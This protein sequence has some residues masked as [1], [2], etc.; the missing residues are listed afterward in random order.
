LAG[1]AAGSAEI[2]AALGR[3]EAALAGLASALLAPTQAFKTFFLSAVTGAQQQVA[4][5]QRISASVATIP[6]A[7]AGALSGSERFREGLRT[8]TAQIRDAAAAMEALRVPAAAIPAAMAGALSGSERFR[9]GLR[10]VTTQ[11]QAAAAAIAA[12]RVPVAAIPAAMA[13]AASGTA[14]FAAGLRTLELQRS[15]AAAAG[16]AGTPWAR[17]L[18]AREAQQAAGATDVWARGLRNLTEQ[19]GIA[20]GASR[21]LTGSLTQHGFAARETARADL[22]LR[23]SL[24]VLAAQST[25][26]SSTLA[27]LAEGL[28]LIGRSTKVVIGGFAAILAI[29]TVY[30]ILTR[31]AREVAEAQKELNEALNQR[32]AARN[33]VSELQR[34][35]EKVLSQLTVVERQIRTLEARG[36]LQFRPTG[37]GGRFGVPTP[38]TDAGIDALIVARNVELF[39]LVRQQKLVQTEIAEV[40]DRQF[41]TIR[42]Q[43]LEQRRTNALAELQARTAR[44]EAV[45]K[46]RFDLA[47]P[48]AIANLWD[49]RP[50]LEWFATRSRVLREAAAGEDALSRRAIRQTKERTDISTREKAAIVANLESEIRVRQIN[51]ETMARQLDSERDLFEQAQASEFRKFLGIGADATKPPRIP[52][53]PTGLEFKAQF[54]VADPDIFQAMRDLAEDLIV[55]LWGQS[56]EDAGQAFG[57]SF[58]SESTRSMEA[59]LALLLGEL[60][61]RARDRDARRFGDVSEGADDATRS[62][63]DLDEALERASIAS[64]RFGATTVR[65]VRA[66]RTAYELLRQRINE[67]TR[68]LDQIVAATHGLGLIDD[69]AARAIG[70]VLN[71][72]DAVGNLRDELGNITTGG[73]LGLVAAGIGL[74]GSVFGG[75]PSE[76]EQERNRILEENNRLLEQNNARLANQRGG[77]GGLA[78]LGVTA[79]ALAE[80]GQIVNRLR[81][82]TAGTAVGTGSKQRL[83]ETEAA[84]EL[85]Q[86][87]A[88]AGLTLREFAARIKETTGL[89]ILDKKGR[90]V[91]SA[92]DQAAEA[93]DAMVEA[94]SHFGTE[95][96]GQLDFADLKARINGVTDGTADAMEQFT[97]DLAAAGAAG[98]T[99]FRDFFSPEDLA[100][101][102][103][104]NKR[105]NALLDL[106]G[107]NSDFFKNNP[108]ALKGLTQADW[109]KILTD[110]AAAME[111]LNKATGN[112]SNSFNDFNLPGGF[113]REALA[114]Q[115][116]TPTPWPP[117]LIPSLPKTRDPWHPPMP[118]FDLQG[119]FVGTDGAALPRFTVTV[120]SGAIVVNA[121]PGQTPT[122]IAEAVVIELRRKAMAQTGDTLQFGF[123]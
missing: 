36:P 72:A 60:E 96:Q 101:P 114:W 106:F 111:E 65:D 66:A 99:F 1:L 3:V 42:R 81:E 83:Q 86:I 73:V 19:S 95:F 6:A 76:A 70:S 71:L 80:L 77:V 115:A 97:R 79:G 34:E 21:R 85:N 27:R 62:V 117:P 7:M 54:E 82:G 121:A 45:A 103:A 98:S 123:N 90:V 88:R 89:D 25:G 56:G 118:E 105:L 52:G 93:I 57:T 58:V 53:G 5:S 30:N 59:N 39:A 41:G 120:E 102:A 12:L 49:D 24:V 61:Q 9:E 8:L 14:T 75:G 46:A 47:P 40:L 116:Q 44:D 104:F 20:T 16:T 119:A 17:G 63:G 29:S 4:A 37:G 15:A 33:P 35:L 113:R 2:V 22:T 108:D 67:V 69:A 28:L 109:V 11:A 38:P 107:P 64:G 100:S 94:A 78:A 112:L 74:L 10:T 48:P 110:G 43:V 32:L 91:A 84:K 18:G 87:L 92:F 50:A 31:K 23:S 122:Q 68:G 26:T 13:A 55:P 51:L